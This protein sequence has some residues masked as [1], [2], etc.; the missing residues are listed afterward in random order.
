MH[1]LKLRLL[2]ALA[3]PL[4]LV[5]ACGGSEAGNQTNDLQIFWNVVGGRCVDAGVLNVQVELRDSGGD[6]YDTNRFLCSNGRATFPQ[7]PTGTYEVI[8]IGLDRQNE[9]TYK[10]GPKRHTVEASEEPSEL[11]PP[12]DLEIRRAT[13]VVTW[14]FTIGRPCSFSGVEEVEVSIWDTAIEQQVVRVVSECDLDLKEQPLLPDGTR[15]MGLVVSDLVPRPVRVEAFAL[16]SDGL[17]RA[18]GVLG[19][20]SLNPGEVRNL[21]IELYP[22]G[23]HANVGCQ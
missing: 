21:D 9:A 5:A 6:L 7:V 22:C 23:G 19:E 18:A 13:L 14:S 8:L 15:P 3:L 4:L 20:M 12:L 2:P 17:R 1:I 16:D 10:A 11:L